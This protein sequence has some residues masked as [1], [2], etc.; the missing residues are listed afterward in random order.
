MLKKI[1]IPVL[2][3]ALLP[4]EGTGTVN[5]VVGLYFDVDE[6]QACILE[7]ESY[8]VFGSCWLLLEN[9]S[10]ECGVAAWEGRIRSEGGLSLGFSNWGGVDAINLGG[11]EEFIV[12][13][14]V[15]RF[16]EDFVVLVEFS[17]F[18]YAPGGVEIM[19]SS[20]PTMGPGY[21]PKYV[22]GCGE[23]DPVT[24]NNAYG[25]FGLVSFSVGY[26]ECPVANG[27]AGVIG[28]SKVPFGYLKSVWRD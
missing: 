27:T 22:C 25:G 23:C 21:G 1:L 13:Y 6:R 10:L 24:M 15:P 12:G 16:S 2:F 7:P 17:Y 19:A 28:V 5:D 4:A 14:S 3:L 20:N 18:S 11:G 8:P 9:I 26:P